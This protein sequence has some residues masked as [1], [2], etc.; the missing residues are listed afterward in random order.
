MSDLSMFFAENVSTEVVEEFVVSERFKDKDGS[1]VKWKIRTITESE[2]DRIRKECIRHPKNKKRQQMPEFDPNE[3]RVKLAVNCVVYPD[4][5][6]KALQ[7][8]Y[9]VIGAESL[10]KAM[11]ISGEAS[12]LYEKIDEING[13]DKEISELVEEVKN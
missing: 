13:F 9:K 6:N 8:S 3:Y 12:V 1:P 11:L 4:L 10:L 2:N 7:D 5:K